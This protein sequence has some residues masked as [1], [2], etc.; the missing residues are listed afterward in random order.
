MFELLTCYYNLFPFTSK[1][2]R[3]S[4]VSALTGSA[5][6]E[7]SLGWEL[8]KIHR[9]IKEAPILWEEKKFPTLR[10]SK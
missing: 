10:V 2:D 5:P 4:G 8:G 7:P 6:Q 9:I 1:K 3:Y